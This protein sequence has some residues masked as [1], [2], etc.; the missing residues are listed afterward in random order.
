MAHKISKLETCFSVL[1]WICPAVLW[2]R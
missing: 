2:Q 1:Q